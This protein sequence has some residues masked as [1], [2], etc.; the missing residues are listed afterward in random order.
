MYYVYIIQSKKNKKVYIG[1]TRNLKR[2]IKEHNDGFTYSTKPNIPFR[3]IY[4][5]LF[6]N[7]EDAL[8]REKYY[9][10]GWGRRFIQKNLKNY[11]A[12]K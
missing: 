11:L 3:L 7:K 12:L 2:R 5:E 8:E 4:C 10:S 1:F 9:Q 6:L